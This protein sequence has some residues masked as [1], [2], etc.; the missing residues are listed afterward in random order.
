MKRRST[1]ALRA[2]V[3]RLLPVQARMVRE[4]LPDDFTRRTMA[5]VRCARART[6]LSESLAP[7]S[8]GFMPAAVGLAFL[9]VMVSVLASLPVREAPLPPAVVQEDAQ[10]EPEQII[11]RDSV[12]VA[13]GSF[14]FG[15][16]LMDPIRHEVEALL[17]T[18]RGL[19]VT[20]LSALPAQPRAWTQHLNDQPGR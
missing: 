10:A 15:D 14:E 8:A 17:D 5:S 13:R 19:G 6:Q 20:M 12:V 2:R 1:R 7:R 9:V 16:P 11:A 4:P 3:E 18:G